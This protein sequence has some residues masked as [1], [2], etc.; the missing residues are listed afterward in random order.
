[1]DLDPVDTLLSFHR[2]QE[3][4]LAALG[5]L[6]V[7]LE[8]GGVDVEAIAAAAGLLRCFGSATALHHAEEEH[9]LMPI[10]ERRIANTAARETFREMRQALEVDHR[11]IQSLWRALRRPLEAIAEGMPRSLS[12]DDVQC[13]RAMCST[14]ICAEEGSV[15]LLALRHLLPGDRTTLGLRIR[16]RRERAVRAA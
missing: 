9:E 13:F 16:V 15:H 7:H 1:M 12:L 6:P 14:H 8:S 4:H 2:R 5:R 11:E 3:R 10:L